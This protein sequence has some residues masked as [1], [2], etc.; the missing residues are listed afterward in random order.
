M[1]VEFHI[2]SGRHVKVTWP[3]GD[4]SDHAVALCGQI[5]SFM[6]T[7]TR[8]RATCACCQGRM[9]A[10]WE[11][12][13]RWLLGS[14]CGLSAT[15]MLRCALGLPVGD[16]NHP[17]DIGDFRRCL[18]LVDSCLWVAAEFPRIAALSPAWE[19]IIFHWEA[20]EAAEKDGDYRTFDK[21]LARVKLSRHPLPHGYAP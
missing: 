6:A 3:D 14:G 8:E 18:R 5:V 16:V 21:V 19:K 2:D 1:T 17:R 15:T 10:R 13:T 20:L 7:T 9:R 11:D 4:L 12:A